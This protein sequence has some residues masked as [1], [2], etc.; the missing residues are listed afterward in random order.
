M[1]NHRPMIPTEAFQKSIDLC[2]AS[3][4]DDEKFTKALRHFRSSYFTDSS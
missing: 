2:I 3:A 1:I 4:P